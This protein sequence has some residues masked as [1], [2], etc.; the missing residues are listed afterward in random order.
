MFSFCVLFGFAHFLSLFRYQ[1][2]FTTADECEARCKFGECFAWTWHKKDSTGWSQGCYLHID[3]WWHPHV[4]TTDTSG[5]WKTGPNIYVADVSA[6]APVNLGLGLFIAPSQKDAD[7]GNFMR[8]NRARYPN[9]VSQETT[10]FPAGWVP[11]GADWDGPGNM[12]TPIYITLEKPTYDLNPLYTNFRIGRGGPCSI[13][14][15]PDS[16]WCSDQPG[17]GGARVFESPTGVTFNKTAMLNGPY[18]AE[19]FKSTAV[20]HTF[21]PAHWSSWMFEFADFDADSLHGT[22]S[23]GG[24]QGARGESKGSEWWLSNVFEELDYPNE[25]FFN[26]KTG[27]LYYFHN[28]TG[29]PPSDYVFVAADLKTLIKIT[30]SKDDPVNNVTLQNIVLTSSAYTYMDPHGIPS[31]GDWALQRSGGV[32][33]E[34]TKNVNIEN[35]LFKNLDGNGL[36]LS[37]FVH[38]TVISN[39]EFTLIGDSA[40]AAWGFTDLVDGTGQEQPRRTI[41]K[42]N[43]IHELGL[44]EKQSSCWFQGK[45]AQTRLSGNICFNGPRA[46]VNFND[47]FGGANV[48][49]DNVLFNLCRESS[50]HG[51]FNSWDRQPFLTDVPD[52]E[53]PTVYPAVN[54][55]TH[56]FII[57]NYGS[58]MCLDNDDGSSYYHHSNNYLI[59][60]GHKSNFGGHNKLSTN[61]YNIYPVVSSSS[62][63][64]HAGLS[65]LVYAARS[66]VAP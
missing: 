62:G 33:L 27:Q 2:L 64:W 3:D 35:C 55:I 44:Y 60:G 21:R 14:T 41:V 32:F 34:G 9:I 58:S 52:P 40:M 54:N 53:N 29:P 43:Y 50:D 28:G 24:F 49:E 1:G 26:P 65:R 5:Y 63:T 66:G 48:M 20:L 45:S 36:F 17:G 15:P 16:Y 6:E 39:N 46:G 8:A 25:Y 18:D 7:T 19:L 57:G 12:G 4:S 10:Q 37:G 47:G 59:Y 22:F 38:D 13:F 11:G 31:G 51:P 23:K 42:N 30:G 61:N 56:N